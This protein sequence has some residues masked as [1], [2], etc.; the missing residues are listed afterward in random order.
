M[1]VRVRVALPDS[2]G[3]LGRLSWTLGVIG[4]DI[5]QVSVLETGSGRAIDELSLRLG[6]LTIDQLTERVETIPGVRVL[7]AWR[8]RA[9]A[10]TAEVAVLG[11][12][13]ADP[14]R[15][16]ATLVDA[17]PDL[18]G[19]D[20]AALAGTGPAP[21]PVLTSVRAPASLALGAITPS[22]PRGHPLADGTHA[23]LAPLTADTVLM[24]ARAAGPAF[25]RTEID[26]LDQLAR[27][28][29]AV[30]AAVDAPVPAGAGPAA[31]TGEPADRL[32]RAG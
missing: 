18:F 1:L 23:A 20:W 15:A 30:L 9:M 2:P 21:T 14:P 17:A 12:L 5:L 32:D 26:R 10:P 19:G 25:H 16:A 24:V 3:S 29:A 7:A 6:S 4:A 27:A 11:Q 22:R 13:A 8:P 28:A 31:G